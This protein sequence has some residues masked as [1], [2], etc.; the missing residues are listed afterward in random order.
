MTCEQIKETLDTVNQSEVA[1]RHLNGCGACRQEAVATVKLV[2]LLHAQPRVKAPADFMAQLQMR[3]A[4]E[5]VNEDALLKNLLQAIP[6]VAAPPD[7]AF[8]VRARLARA[9]APASNPLA[10]FGEWLKQ[11][12]TFGQAAS[13]MAA[14]ALIAVFTTWQMSGSTTAPVNLAQVETPAVAQKFVAPPAVSDVAP[15]AVMQKVTRASRANFGVT[16]AK[17]TLA[18]TPKTEVAVATVTNRS[19]TEPAIYSSKTGQEVHIG[20]DGNTYGRQLMKV[21]AVQPKAEALMASAAF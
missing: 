20:R 10:A 17:A 8:R 6:A 4:T 16:S 3:M 15:T 19:L 5:T 21:M 11:S 12:F 7:F 2:S 9:E 13:A 14:V 18:V 1:T